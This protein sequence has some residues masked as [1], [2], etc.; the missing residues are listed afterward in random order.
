MTIG[1]VECEVLYAG[2]QGSFVGLDQV[3]VRVPRELAGRGQ[4]NL[5][6]NITSFGSSNQFE[7]GSGPTFSNQLENDSDS[8]ASNQLE[9]EITVPPCPNPPVVRSFDPKTLLAGGPLEINGSDF[10]STLSGNLVRVGGTEAMVNSAMPNQLFAK[11]PFGVAGGPITVRVGQ[12]E[13]MSMT[14][15]SMITSASVIVQNTKL[16]PLEKVTVRIRSASVEKGD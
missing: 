14:P 15:A 11:V 4:L 1:G 2:P 13:G 10:S 3:N 12:C 6:L 7:N 5:I 9:M 8:G 16:K